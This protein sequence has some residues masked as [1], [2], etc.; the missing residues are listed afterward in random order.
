MAALRRW[1]GVIGAVAV[2]L[3]L[4]GLLIWEGTSPAK[5]VFAFG[6]CILVI[7]AI[8][9]LQNR[10][11]AAAVLVGNPADERQRMIHLR[12]IEFA[13]EVTIVISLGGYIAVELMHGD[14]TGFAV[15][16]ASFGFAYTGAVLW[17]R[18]RL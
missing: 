6:V 2:S 14:S 7:I 16:A 3:V 10:S 8:G 5:T 12:A 11:E 4:G 9:A 15:V 13:G 1:Q 18:S 17:L